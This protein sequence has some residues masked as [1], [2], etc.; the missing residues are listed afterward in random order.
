MGKI[1]KTINTYKAQI[2]IVLG[3]L[4]SFFVTLEGFG[5]TTATIYALVAAILSAVVYYLKNGF[6]D[7]LAN[8]GVGIIKMIIDMVEKNNATIASN[9]NVV[10]STNPNSTNTI[11]KLSDEEIKSQLLTYIKGK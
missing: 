3:A 1:I 2:I 9:N 6:D 4:I 7:T 8:A 5:G 11:I 10:S